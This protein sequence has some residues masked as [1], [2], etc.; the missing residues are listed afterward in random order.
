MCN[1][2]F[3]KGLGFLWELWGLKAMYGFEGDCTRFIGQI[4]IRLVCV[5]LSLYIY[6]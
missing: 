6:I 4:M 3:T 5:D 2:G 1:T